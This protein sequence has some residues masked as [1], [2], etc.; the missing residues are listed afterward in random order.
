M[1]AYTYS[2]INLQAG[3]K[4]TNELVTDENSIKQSIMTILS[5]SY[6]SRFFRPDFGSSIERLLFEPMDDETK[7]ALQ[8][9]MKKSI[10]AWEPRIKIT[11]STVTADMVNQ[12]YHVT[13]SYTIPVLSNK[14]YTLAFDLQPKL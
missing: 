8:L 7:F 9:T 2:D 14:I 10:K 13:I 1:A 4:S 6:G 11:K 3:E 12:S 5:T